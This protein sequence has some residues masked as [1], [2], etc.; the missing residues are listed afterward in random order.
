MFQ[1]VLTI[2]AGRKLPGKDD[3]I[4]VEHVRPNYITAAY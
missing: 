4:T 2:L 3:E 1:I